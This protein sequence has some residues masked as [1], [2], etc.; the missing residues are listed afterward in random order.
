MKLKIKQVISI[1]LLLFSLFIGSVLFIMSYQLTNNMP[2]LFKGADYYFNI[3]VQLSVSVIS[4][5]IFYIFIELLPL[6]TDKKR[7]IKFIKRPLIK[8]CYTVVDMYKTLLNDMDV[9]SLIE[10]Y[11]DSTYFISK[12]ELLDMTKPSPCSIYY[13]GDSISITMDEPIAFSVIMQLKCIKANIENVLKYKSLDPKLEIILVNM[14]NTG[15]MD[16]LNLV[17]T[18]MF[19]DYLYDFFNK[20]SRNNKGAYYNFYMYSLQLLKYCYEENIFSQEE[21]DYFKLI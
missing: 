13:T 9:T 19:N 21:L 15:V 7:T 1:K 4:A 11:A 10:N 5:I 16:L 18:S 20:Q 2:E 8:I 17:N 6:Y 12:I 3:G 14:A